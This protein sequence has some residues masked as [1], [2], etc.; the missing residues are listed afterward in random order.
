MVLPFLTW[1]DGEGVERFEHLVV[2]HV[3][4]YRARQSAEDL[5]RLTSRGQGRGQVDL[6]SSTHPGERPQRAG[7]IGLEGGGVGG[8]KPAV[9]R[10]EHGT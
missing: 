9:D 5:S 7:E 4:V 8:D 10:D 3:R 1:L 6:L 2:D